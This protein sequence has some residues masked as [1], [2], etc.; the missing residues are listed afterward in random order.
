MRPPRG[1][2]KPHHGNRYLPPKESSMSLRNIHTTMAM[3]MTAISKFLLN[4]KLL[5]ALKV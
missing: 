4:L 2:I 3:A 1:R 5:A